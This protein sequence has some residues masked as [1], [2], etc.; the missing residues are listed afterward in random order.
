MKKIGKIFCYI[1]F[2]F[3]VFVK[4]IFKKNIKKFNEVKIIMTTK[5]AFI[6]EIKN[7]KIIAAI[8]ISKFVKKLTKFNIYTV[9]N[10][11]SDVRF[12]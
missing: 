1:K 9:V 5:T 10:F 4:F 2:G 3:T 8:N 6:P 12:L 7:I 11:I